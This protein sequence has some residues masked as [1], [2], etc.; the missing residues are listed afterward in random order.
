V[1]APRNWEVDRTQYDEW[2]GFIADLLREG[3]R[4]MTYVNPMLVA[5]ISERGTPFTRDLYAEAH[6]KGYLVRQGSEV[7]LGYSSAALVDL[8]NPDA[9]AWLKAVIKTQMLQSGVSGWMS[10]FGEACPLDATLFSGVSGARYH[11]QYPADWAQLNRE[12]RSQTVRGSCTTGTAP[13]QLPGESRVF[14]LRCAQ[15]IDEYAA[16]TSNPALALEACPPPHIRG[17]R[18]LERS[19]APLGLEPMYVSLLGNRRAWRAPQC[20]Q[21]Q[22][23]VSLPGHS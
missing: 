20:V 17:S 14:C 5:N 22:R 13:G 1:F 19:S 9:R 15:A 6:A 8:T 18:H 23:N 16:E 3:V 11:S 4:V 7:W 2:E 12:V 10:D 21:G